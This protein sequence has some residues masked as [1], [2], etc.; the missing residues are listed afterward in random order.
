VLFVTPLSSA[1]RDDGDFLENGT[2][3]VPAPDNLVFYS[4][5]RSTENRLWST[6]YLIIV[7]DNN[8]TYD[9]FASFVVLV[10]M[11]YAQLVV[12]V[13][14]FSARIDAGPKGNC[15]IYLFFNNNASMWHKLK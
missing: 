7:D 10:V 2:E 9:L 15:D 1:V 5:V 12:R 11:S 3:T 14:E 8:D 4:R 6:I 13:C